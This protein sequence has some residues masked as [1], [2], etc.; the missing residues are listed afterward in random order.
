[1]ALAEYGL[2]RNRFQQTL[3]GLTVLLG[4]VSACAQIVGIEDTTVTRG[5]A[6]SDGS[7][8][9]SAGTPAAHAGAANAG[10]SNAGQSSGGS[11]PAGGAASAG[12]ATGGG[13]AG[14]AS[15]G[16][17]GGA[18]GG[19]AG[20]ASGGGAAGGGAGGGAGQLGNGGGAASEC[21]CSAPKPTCENGKCV[22]RGPIMAKATTFYIDS[23]EV[24]KAQ[25]DLFLAAK[26]SDSSGQI[27]E[28]A[29]NKSY[30]PDGSVVDDP[31]P[32][33]NVDWCDAAAYCKWAD[34]RLCGA[35]GGGPIAADDADDPTK[36]QMNLACAGADAE[37]YPYGGFTLKPQACNG[38][39]FMAD[40]GKYPMCEGHYAGI[41]DLVGNAAEWLDSCDTA[42]G[43]D[44]SLDNCELGG[45]SNINDQ[46]TCQTHFS[47]PRNDGASV[48]GFRCCSK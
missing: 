7:S 11:A 17:A 4:G 12:A 27:S 36:A 42:G 37:R 1:M 24:T 41:F 20:G 19:A 46:Y 13:A 8:A 2:R 3:L 35:I 28:C 45:G 6:G 18:S 21:P 48:F 43:T 14:G 38:S 16:A 25:Y 33:V 32:I 39:G 34:K 26:G 47:N 23:T 40:V 5:D 22:V 29:W 31:R 15:G 44:R 9:G 30:T 10:T